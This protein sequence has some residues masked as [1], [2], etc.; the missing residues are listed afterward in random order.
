MDV[1]DFVTFTLAMGYAY[2]VRMFIWPH[3]QEMTV[4]T[5]MSAQVYLVLLNPSCSY[6]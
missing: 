1:K 5:T 3:K 2:M 6:A 4:M